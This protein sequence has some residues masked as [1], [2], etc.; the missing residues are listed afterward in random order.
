MSLYRKLIFSVG[1]LILLFGLLIAWFV[2]DKAHHEADELMDGQL[3]QLAQLL[4]TVAMAATSDDH[5]FVNGK[6]SFPER[7]DYEQPLAFVVWESDG[8]VVMRSSNSSSLSLVEQYGFSV[9]QLGESR[10]R[11]YARRG[12]QAERHIL[13]AQPLEVRQ[14]AATEV[15]LQVLYP[16][17]ITL[18]LTL[19][20]VTLIVWQVIKPLNRIATEVESRK[21]NDL[22]P[23]DTVKTPLEIAPLIAAVNGLLLRLKSRMAQEQRFT[24]DAAH[25]LRTPIAGIKINAQVAQRAQDDVVRSRALEAVLVGLDRSERLVEQMLRLARLDQDAA[26]ELQI[27]NMHEFMAQLFML[28]QQRG[29]TFLQGKSI[30]LVE[31]I[32]ENALVAIDPDMLEIAVLNLLDNAVRHSPRLSSITCHLLLIDGGIEIQ[33]RNPL[34]RQLEPSVLARLKERF[35]RHAASGEI[36]G[37][38]LGLAIVQRIADLHRIHFVLRQDAKGSFCASL[39]PF[40]LV[41]GNHAI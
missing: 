1:S 18:V 16:I 23:L 38:G 26:T 40:P 29:N 35:F 15:A 30:T 10:W 6:K 33:V 20:I 22:T 36:T 32:E 41:S 28:Y 4:D 37:S 11:T 2:Y 31:R 25:E 12:A 14:K 13:V 17:G 8:Q 3:V 21:A 24:A 39:G 19:L 7:H 9:R 34:A 5:R 27:I